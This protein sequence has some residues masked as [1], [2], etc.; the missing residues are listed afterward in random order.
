MEKENRIK[1]LD[2]SKEDHYEGEVNGLNKPH[3][4]GK[5]THTTYHSGGSYV[6]EGEFRNGKRHGEGVLIEGNAPYEDRY[7]GEWANDM[8]E[9]YGTQV[10]YYGERYEGEWRRNEHHGYGVLTKEDGTV[11]EGDIFDM[12]MISGCGK[13]TYPNGETYEGDIKGAKRYGHGVMTYQD[14]HVYDGQWLNDMPFDE[15]LLIR[16][17]EFTPEII[18]DFCVKEASWT[19]EYRDLDVEEGHSDAGFAIDGKIHGFMWRRDWDDGPGSADYYYCGLVD[20][21]LKKIGFICS[22]RYQPQRPYNGFQ[23]TEYMLP[24]LVE[25]DNKG[26]IVFCGVHKDGVR[27]GLGS[28]FTYND[29][30]EITELQGLWQNGKLTH[31]REGDK[32][33]PV[34]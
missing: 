34:L 6:Y 8:R 31:R 22:I 15:D 19:H 28:E 26:R 20:D 4:R 3:G 12:G 5:L 16:T 21:Q 25:R 7:E 30:G 9:G 32:L 1:I 24:G 14:G 11:Y 18:K 2:L 29:D 27:H 33:V 23:E 17:A 10:F 13:I